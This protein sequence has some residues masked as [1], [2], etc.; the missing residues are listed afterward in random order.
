ME[1]SPKIAPAQQLPV[2][3]AD[4]KLWAQDS[5]PLLAVLRPLV[6]RSWGHL[7]PGV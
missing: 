7:G 2:G 3:L 1:I 6:E 5:W 4:T